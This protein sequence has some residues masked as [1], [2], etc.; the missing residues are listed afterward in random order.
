MKRLSVGA[1]AV[2]H[3]DVVGG[4]KILR[5]SGFGLTPSGDDFIAGL[6]IAMH[7][8]Q[9]MFGWDLGELAG[10]VYESSRSENILS[11]TLLTFA[12]EGRGTERTKNLVTAVLC[13]TQSRVREHTERLLRVGETSG[14][15]LGTG[16][17]MAMQ[18]RRMFLAACRPASV[19]S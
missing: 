12:R 17:C 14:A 6:L 16:F 3:G 13:G 10:V 9:R 4:V 18:S 19:E 11:D 5:G 2:F 15:D 1:K 8:L 7:L